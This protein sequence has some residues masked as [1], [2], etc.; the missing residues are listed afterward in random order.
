MIHLRCL[1]L[2]ALLCAHSAGATAAA[3]AA[4]PKERLTIGGRLLVDADYYESFWSKDGDNSTSNVEVRNARLE[5]EY[6]F[7]KGWLG[8]L[9]ID[10]DYDSDDGDVELGSAYLRYTKW[11][12]A[13][14]TLGKMKEPVGL[15]RNT[16]FDRLLTI[17]GSMMSTAFTP[18]KNWGVHLRNANKRRS[19]ALAVVVEDDQDDD[20]DEDEPTAISGRVTFSPINN[21]EQLLQ[22]GAS[23]S[24]R[25]LNENTFRIRERA[26][27]GSADRVVRGAEFTADSQSVLGVEGIWRRKSFLLQAEYMI[28]RVEELDGPDWDYDGYYVTG[29]YFLTGE[30]HEF[31]DAKLRTVKPLAKSGAWE[32]VAR[33]SY[34]DARERGLGSQATVT[35][36]GVNYYYGRHIKVMFAYLHPDISGSVRHADPDGDALSL[37]LQYVH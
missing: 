22:I 20:Y 30:Q 34:L 37:R 7:P 36:L 15:E 3:D 29:S 6:D 19:W 31:R 8:K 2:L 33:H 14:I 9:Q 35:T 4:E 24:L 16:R 26:E 13:D 21:D 1:I 17:E 12:F 10:G 18:G 27:V 23:G 32:L 28:T 11:D 25:D 5:I